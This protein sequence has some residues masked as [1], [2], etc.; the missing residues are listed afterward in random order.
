MPQEA[1]HDR[2]HRG[3]A[4]A[5]RARPRRHR[6]TALLEAEQ[7]TVGYGAAPVLHGVDLTVAA[8]SITAVLGA[9][10]AGKT[11]L[12]RT[13]SGLLKPQAGSVLV[14]GKNVVGMKPEDV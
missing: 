12:L 14:D 4:R 2:L 10:G 7:L 5:E 1:P 6:M 13:L 11:T 8:G 3:E 9:N